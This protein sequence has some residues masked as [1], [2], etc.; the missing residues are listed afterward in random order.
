MNTVDI[1][2]VQKK[3]YEK[4]K[5]SG[6]DLILRSFVMGDEFEHILNRLLKESSDG[7]HFTPRVKQLFRCFEECPYK[8]LR[9]IVIGQD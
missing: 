9:V 2:D 6:W 8:D 7:K 4:L 1:K 5:P 3:L